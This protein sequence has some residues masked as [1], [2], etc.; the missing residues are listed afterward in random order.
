L[1]YIKNAKQ[2]INNIAMQFAQHWATSPVR[3]TLGVINENNYK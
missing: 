3:I 2:L 1:G